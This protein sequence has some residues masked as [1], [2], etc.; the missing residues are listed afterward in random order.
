MVE[1]QIKERYKNIDI[2]GLYIKHSDSKE[3]LIYLLPMNGL[4]EKKINPKKYA[5]YK[6]VKSLSKSILIIEDFFNNRYGW[7]LK[8]GNRK[9]DSIILEYIETF[10]KNRNYSILS[11]Y[12]SSKGGFAALNIGLQSY[13]INKIYA[14]IPIIDVR[15]Y[16]K[17]MN[18]KDSE[19]Y[20]KKYEDYIFS[21]SK[22]VSNTKD[23]FIITGINDWQ[24]EEQ[25]K[26]IS[27]LMLNQEYYN[28]YLYID[29]N[30]LNH[31]EYVR[32]NSDII[33]NVLSDKTKKSITVIHS[34]NK[35]RGNIS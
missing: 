12:G 14:A 10:Y 32:K 8:S 5:G 6:L 35:E 19:T 28:I 20:F 21:I 22:E 29:Y 11:I 30:I 33:K 4:D 31:G 27:Y 17:Q 15:K 13:C 18:N 1:I 16:Y 24:Y 2:E 34:Q 23:I 3:L 25:N 26:L 9:I 7:Y